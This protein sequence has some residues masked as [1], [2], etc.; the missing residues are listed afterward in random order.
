MTRAVHHRLHMFQ[1]DRRREGLQRE[2]RKSR[3]C[4]DKL[5]CVAVEIAGSDYFKVL[6]QLIARNRL[7]IQATFTIEN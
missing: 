7:D 1:G 3:P 2:H 6:V 4:L 5:V